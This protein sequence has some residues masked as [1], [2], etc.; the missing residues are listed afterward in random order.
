MAIKR[1]RDEDLLELETL[2]LRENK[3]MS[4]AEVMDRLGVTR[5]FISGLQSRVRKA[6]AAHPC[7]CRRKA[8]RDCG[9]GQRWWQS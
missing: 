9:M 8:N 5:G 6:V 1:T 4:G 3:G 2:F 7:R